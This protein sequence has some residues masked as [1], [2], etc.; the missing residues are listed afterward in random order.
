MINS[1]M[2]Q[3]IETMLWSS[4]DSHDIPLDDKY[5][6]DDI[7]QEAMARI[8][9]DCKD[10]IDAISEILIDYSYIDSQLA[11]DF[12]LTRNRHGAGFWDGDY[13]KE[14]GE[15]L[16]NVSHGF[17]EINPYIGDDNKIYLG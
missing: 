17:G 6:I 10:F 2:K 7:S 4:T 5:G 8:E 9:K 3:Y 1:F 11:H 14:L 12:W 16:T 15:L 13:P